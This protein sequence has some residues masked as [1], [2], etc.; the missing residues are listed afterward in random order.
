MSL[1]GLNVL[2]PDVQISES[3]LKNFKFMKVSDREWKN[4]DGQKLGMIYSL[5]I[6]KDDNDYGDKGNHLNEFE[7]IDVKMA[8]DNLPVINHRAK[9]TLTDVEKFKFYNESYGKADVS[10]EA[11]VMVVDEH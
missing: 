5:A 8:G 7:K 1:S 6:I 10:V 4:S 9:V 3:A 2:R 11:K